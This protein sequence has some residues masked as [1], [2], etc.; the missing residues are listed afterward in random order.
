MAHSTQ[1]NAETIKQ[2]AQRHDDT[3]QEI[4]SQLDALKAQVDSTLA[5]SGSAATRAL[6]T[7]T[8]D[9]VERVRKSVLSH[10]HAMAENMRKEA[11]AQHQMDSDNMQSI[12][13]L[14]METSAFLGS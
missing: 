8:D 1:L 3:A 2:Q 10:M 7:T 5:A 9:W 6:S 4:S 14:N 13:N 11:D 12:L